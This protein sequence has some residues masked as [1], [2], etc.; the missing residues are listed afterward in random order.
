MTQQSRPKCEPRGPTGKSLRFIRRGVKTSCEK[1][2]SSVFRK[3]VVIFAHP[4]SSTECDDF[5][6]MHLRKSDL[7]PME[8]TTHNPLITTGRFERDQTHRARIDLGQPS[9]NSLLSILDPPYPTFACNGNV[10]PF[11]GDINPDHYL[12]HAADLRQNMDLVST[13]DCYAGARPSLPYAC[14]TVTPAVPR[15][16]RSR[17][18]PSS[19]RGSAGAPSFRMAAQ[20]CNPVRRGPSAQ[21]RMSLEYWV[22][23]ATTSSEPLPTWTFRQK[24]ISCAGQQHPDLL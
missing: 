22:A 1:Y 19:N 2:V 12:A 7:H 15:C 13:P 23:R 5:A 21:A 11:L 17:E 4:A 6:R 3:Y 16:P 14:Q 10:D 18:D 20:S 24:Y 8:T 9:I